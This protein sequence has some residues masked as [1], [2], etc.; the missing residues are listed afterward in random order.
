MQ[1]DL[2]GGGGKCRE[3]SA[4]ARMEPGAAWERCVLNVLVAMPTIPKIL[5]VDDNP[6]EGIFLEDGL[7]SAGWPAAITHFT[8]VSEAAAQLQDQHGPEGFDLVL[9]D[10]NLPGT[11]LE[12]AIPQLMS[13]P[14]VRE[15]PILVLSV[16]SRDYDRELLLR[17]GVKGILVKPAS[18]AEYAKFAEELES[19]LTSAPPPPLAP[20]RQPRGASPPR[21]GSGT[22]R[23]LR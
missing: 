2:P 11:S 14:L 19:H 16:I 7:S 8:S 15:A 23:S 3:A 6:K 17:A 5:L 13:F 9:I 18:L 20:P 22:Y 21:S 12:R 1:S 4:A 10:Y